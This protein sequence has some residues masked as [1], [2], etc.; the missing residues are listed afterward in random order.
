MPPFKLAFQS[1]IF[2]SAAAGGYADI[3]K[4][5]PGVARI[6]HTKNWGLRLGAPPLCP[7]YVLPCVLVLFFAPYAMPYAM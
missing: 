6:L 1:R 5:L 3:S 4:S 7:P 2:L